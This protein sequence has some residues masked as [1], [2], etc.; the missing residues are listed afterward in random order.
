MAAG[1]YEVHESGKIEAKRKRMAEPSV[2]NI[3]K[4]SASEIS[5]LGNSLARAGTCTGT[6]G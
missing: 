2:F 4:M 6:A 1:L 3:L 5:D